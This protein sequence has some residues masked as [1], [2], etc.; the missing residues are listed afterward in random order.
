MYKIAIFSS[1]SGT[2]LQSFIE[3][4][5]KGELEGIK[6][7]CL[8]TNKAHCGAVEKAKRAGIPVHILEAKGKTREEFDRQVM[9]ILATHPV[10]LIVLGGYMRLIGPEMIQRYKNRILNV[11][12]SLLPKFAGDM[13][14]SVHQA[15]LDAGEKETGMTIHYVDEGVDTGEILLQKKVTIKADD[16]LESLKQKVQALEKEW[17]PKVV[18]KLVENDKKNRLKQ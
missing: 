8:V 7:C 13:N 4:R 18:K 17:Y 11:H 12:P 5:D 16:T 3:A 15:V 9:A 14:R 1:T 2:N 10:D 6:I